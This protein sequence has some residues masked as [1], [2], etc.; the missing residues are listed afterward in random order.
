MDIL[1]A[2]NSVS[3]VVVVVI[4]VVEGVE[5]Y[6]TEEKAGKRGSNYVTFFC[7]LFCVTFRFDFSLRG[8]LPKVS[9]L[10]IFPL[11][12][13]LCVWFRLFF[14]TRPPTSISDGYDTIFCS[15]HLRK[16]DV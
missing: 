2:L 5:K 16:C 11:T 8:G 6:T 13:S 14:C 1:W 12:T 7:H 4:V 9:W 15:F 10:N 3:E